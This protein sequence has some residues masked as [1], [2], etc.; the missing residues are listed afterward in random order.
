MLRRAR[1]IP[2]P[3][4]L[5]TL[6]ALGLALAS[7]ACED[8][9]SQPSEDDAL[10]E[11]EVMALVHGLAVVGR[12][13]PADSAASGSS[14]SEPTA[15]C[16][17][18]GSVEFSGTTSADSTE[19]TR[20]LRSDLTMVPQ[21]CRFTARDVTFTADGA[22]HVR[23]VGD[24]TITGFFEEVELDYDVTGSVAWKTGSPMRSGTCAIDLDLEGEIELPGVESTD[25]LAVVT[26]SLSGTMCGAAVALPLDSISAESRKITQVGGS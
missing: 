3:R 21:A 9:V 15:T 1:S 23:Q 18:G 22:P 13:V 4:L 16:P 14:A 5:V 10:T 26:G 2:E 25:T 6:T 11:D 20:I 12:L 7:G 19:T 8:R 17:L 24:L